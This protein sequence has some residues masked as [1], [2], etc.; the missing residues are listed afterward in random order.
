MPSIAGGHS[1][2]RQGER[3]IVNGR[4]GSDDSDKR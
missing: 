1:E 4:D 2:M 3:E